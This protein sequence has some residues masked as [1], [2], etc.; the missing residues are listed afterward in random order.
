MSFRAWLVVRIL[1]ATIKKSLDIDEQS[2]EFEKTVSRYKVP[3]DVTIKNEVWDNVPV[4][5][6]F[7]IGE[8]PKKVILYLHGGSYTIGSPKIYRFFLGALAKAANIPTLAVDYRLAPMH[9]FPAAMNDAIAVYKHL[10]ETGYRGEDIVFLGDSAGGNLVLTTGMYLRDHQM[11]MPKALCMI[12]PWLDLVMESESIKKNASKDPVCDY[13]FDYQSARQ[14]AGNVSLTDPLISPIYGSLK[15][16]PALFMHA[17]TLEMG[18]EDYYTLIQK[19]KQEGADVT[20][21]V[22][23]GLF[24]D[25]T[26]FYTETPEGKQSFEDLTAFIM[27]KLR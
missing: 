24:H 1:R 23:K 22:W 21:K 6:I 17:G 18:F 20:S 16:L 5:W 7:P 19:A 2:K 11:E 27:S 12:S 14:Y 9:P 3:E 26:I 25:M 8:T 4:E 15:N 10:L 13:G